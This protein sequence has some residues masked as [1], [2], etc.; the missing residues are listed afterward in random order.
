MKKINDC[1]YNK[2]KHECTHT[3]YCIFNNKR[4]QLDTNINK[5]TEKL[6]TFTNIKHS[7]INNEIIYHD[8]LS[9]HYE[10]SKQKYTIPNQ[11]HYKL[12]IKIKDSDKFTKALKKKIEY[13]KYDLQNLKQFQYKIIHGEIPEY[14]L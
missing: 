7:F 1:N 5:L 12:G 10:I 11:T 8:D 4:I 6:E 13:I 2:G 9:E 3:Q 14:G